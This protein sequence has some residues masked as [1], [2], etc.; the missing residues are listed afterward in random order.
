MNSSGKGRVRRRNTGVLAVSPKAYAEF[1][2]RL[3][4][5]AEP[6]ERLRRTLRMPLPWKVAER[7]R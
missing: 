1:V 4:A 7:K 2:A 3:D 5:P 6:N